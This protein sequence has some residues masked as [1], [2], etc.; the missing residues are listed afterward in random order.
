MKKVIFSFATFVA[1]LSTSCNKDVEV[2]A[3]EGK[4]NSLRTMQVRGIPV[5]SISVNNG[6]SSCILNLLVFNSWDDYHKIIFE[7]DEQIDIDVNAFDAS[8]DASQLSD[9]EYNAKCEAL[10]FDEDNTLR[11]FE[12]NLGFCSLRRKIETA[13][14]A[15]LDQQ[16]VGNWDL[17]TDPDDH[18]IDDETERT[19]LNEQVQVGIRDRKGGI[20]IY[21]LR[22]DEGNYEEVYNMDTSALQTVTAAAISGNQVPTGTPNVVS[23]VVKPAETGIG[24]CKDKVKEV[25]IEV[26]A[27]NTFRIQRKSKL[28][29]AWG[30]TCS[31][32]SC[33]S[34]TGSRLK[35]RT[36]G[37]KRK[38]N[39]GWKGTRSLITA[40]IYG[41][42]PNTAGAAFIDCNQEKVVLEHREKRRR[43]VK[44]KA[45]SSTFIAGAGNPTTSNFNVRDNRL[46]SYH[47]QGTFVIMKDYYDMPQE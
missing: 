10:G 28:R 37:Y 17:S 6:V 22:D 2:A 4:S 40:A 30:T 21:Q 20:V 19:L 8:I 18:F 16:G 42:Q 32:G 24:G 45:T 47:K 15:W 13:E 26:N 34:I 36:K 14:N 39:G 43:R 9:D 27:E 44:V 11:R 33:S 25:K 5:E 12:R 38:S 7:L 31:N 3:T 23:N 46:F 29:R 35:A 1:V 41:M